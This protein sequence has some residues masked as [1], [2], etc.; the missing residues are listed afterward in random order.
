MTNK[1]AFIKTLGIG[2][3]TL[4]SITPT[5][6]FT[7]SPDP[8][9]VP[10]IKA[11]VINANGRMYPLSVV[12]KTMVQIKEQIAVNRCMVT[13]DDVD[14]GGSDVNLRNVAGV[15]K[16]VKIEN[17]VLYVRWTPLNTLPGCLVSERLNRGMSYDIVTAGISTIKNTGVIGDDYKFIKAF[18]TTDSA[19]KGIV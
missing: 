13:L 10:I 17:D 12:E 15:I 5:E 2:I 4:A 8:S 16:D 6:A 19:W 14:E 7:A 11:N 18:L 3:V 9:W 1:R